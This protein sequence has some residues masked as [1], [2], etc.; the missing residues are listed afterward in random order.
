MEGLPPMAVVSVLDPI[1][2]RP[3]PA[4]PSLS[5]GH[6]LPQDCGPDRPLPAPRPWRVSAQSSG[7]SL[8]QVGS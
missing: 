8:R 6:Q 1:L 4:Q 2:P 5:G 7:A 3:K